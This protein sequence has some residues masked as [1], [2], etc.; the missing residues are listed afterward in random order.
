MSFRGGS[1]SRTWNDGMQTGEGEAAAPFRTLSCGLSK[2]EMSK[3]A[4]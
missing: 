3:A 1:K 2:T 4:Y